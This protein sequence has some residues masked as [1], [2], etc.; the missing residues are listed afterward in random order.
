ME[1]SL[2]CLNWQN[3]EGSDCLSQIGGHICAAYEIKNLLH[4]ETET[5]RYLSY[6]FLAQGSWGRRSKEC[7]A[8]IEKSCS[9]HSWQAGERAD[10]NPEQA[11]AAGI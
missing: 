4:H 1:G 11:T 8:A 9:F 10:L 7:K 2:K 3:L 5:L 6:R